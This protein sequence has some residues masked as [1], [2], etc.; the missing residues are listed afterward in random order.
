MKIMIEYAYKQ[1]CE[2]CFIL[3]DPLCDNCSGV[4]Y[5]ES[6]SVDLPDNAYDI[7]ALKSSRGYTR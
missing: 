1:I 2:E 7:E 6:T 5:T 4:G 3:V